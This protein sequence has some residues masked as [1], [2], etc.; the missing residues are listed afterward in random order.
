MLFKTQCLTKLVYDPITGFF[1]WTSNGTHG[2]KKG[3]I[4]GCKNKNGY[5]VLSIAGR[6]MLAHRVAWLFSNGEFPVGNLDH[7]N[8]N[9]SDN[10]ISNLREATYAQNA[11]NRTKNVC[12]KSGYKGVIWHKR[13][14]KWQASITVNKKCIHLGYYSSVEEANEAYIKS[15]VTYQTH[16]IFNN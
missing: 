9:K 14:K 6:K 4:A 16:S 7:I 13:D 12:N 2:V 3:D 5:I 8:R 15:S 11:Q 10:R 1:T